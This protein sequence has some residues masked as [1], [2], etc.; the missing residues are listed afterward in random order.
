MPR[1]RKTT[2]KKRIVNPW[3]A[4]DLKSLRR[5]AHRS[6]ARDIAKQ[7]KRSEGAVRQKASSLGVSLQLR[8]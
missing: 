2:K 4:G 3:T 1:P 5:L 8:S 7:L 6:H